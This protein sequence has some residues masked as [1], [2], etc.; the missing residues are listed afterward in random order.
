MY[1]II[2]YIF[3][4]ILCLQ[5]KGATRRRIVR[6]EIT[7]EKKIN[8]GIWETV[9]LQK[10]GLMLHKQFGEIYLIDILCFLKL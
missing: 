8:V 10:L 5:L 4:R 6:G 2:F 1:L 9:W 3:L 7:R